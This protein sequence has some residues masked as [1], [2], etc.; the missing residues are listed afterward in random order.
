MDRGGSEHIGGS[1]LS[2]A[3][4]LRQPS[5]ST[6]FGGGTVV[7]GFDGSPEPFL[8]EESWPVGGRIWADLAVLAKASGSEVG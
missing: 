7:V 6:V 4:R 1:S 8:T 5:V 3:C 2:L